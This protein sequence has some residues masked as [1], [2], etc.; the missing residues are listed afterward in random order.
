MNDVSEV[1]FFFFYRMRTV[2][3]HAL[4]IF[5][6]LLSSQHFSLD[7]FSLLHS[8]SVIFTAV[9]FISVLL[10]EKIKTKTKSAVKQIEHKGRKGCTRR[11]R[12][13]NL[14]LFRVCSRRGRTTTILGGVM[15]PDIPNSHSSHAERHQ[16]AF[17]LTLKATIPAF[18]PSTRH[19]PSRLC[20]PQRSPETT[21]NKHTSN[22][23]QQ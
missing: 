4:Y 20:Q 2:G 9:L 22:I 6:S 5:F 23:Q 10:I 16:H 8:P 12:P 15:E 14:N 7:V 17:P 19:L 11:E 1:F 18:P 3:P 21:N 13:N